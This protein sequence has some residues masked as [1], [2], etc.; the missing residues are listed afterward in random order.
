MVIQWLSRKFSGESLTLFKH[1]GE[2]LRD[3]P[4]SY[5]GWWWNPPTCFKHCKVLQNSATMT[6]PTMSDLSEMGWII[7]IEYDIIHPPGL[8]IKQQTKPCFSIYI[9]TKAWFRL[10]FNVKIYIYI[11][12]YIYIYIHHIPLG[13]WG[14]GGCLILGSG[15]FPSQAPW[16]WSGTSPWGGLQD[17]APK[18]DVNV[19][20]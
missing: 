5:C 20:L 14:H 16:N 10:L 13:P 3:N 8:H 9:S 11:H 6:S 18:R 7:Q 12:I 4:R 15:P 1:T 17:G 19:G 2:C